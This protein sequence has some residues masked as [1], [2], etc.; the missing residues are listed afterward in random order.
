[1]QIR[2]KHEQLM[3]TIS[4]LIYMFLLK[5]AFKLFYAKCLGHANK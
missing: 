2:T 1:M 4:N 3:S 5:H